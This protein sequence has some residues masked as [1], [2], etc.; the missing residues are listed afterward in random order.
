M[1]LSW[2]CNLFVVKT[3]GLIDGL[4]MKNKETYINYVRITNAIGYQYTL[5]STGV[6]IENTP[7]LPGKV[8]DG[9]IEG[10]DLNYLSSKTRVYANWNGF[11]LP[12]NAI[13]QVDVESGEYLK[14]RRQVFEQSLIMQL[15]LLWVFSNNCKN[16]VISVCERENV[17]IKG[18]WIWMH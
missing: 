9:D 7:L 12:P 15:Y 13:V 5:R 1:K 16:L 11:G 2:F 10:Y 8:Y 3:S 17:P 6:T 4:Q 18:P 14:V